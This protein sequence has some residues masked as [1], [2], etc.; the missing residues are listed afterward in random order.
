[1]P[2]GEPVPFYLDLKRFK[3]NKAAAEKF[4]SQV[5]GVLATINEGVKLYNDPRHASKQE[6]VLEMLALK[7]K[8]LKALQ[9]GFAFSNRFE[10]Y[11]AYVTTTLEQHVAAR[12]SPKTLANLVDEM[13]QF[14]AESFTQVL[15]KSKDNKAL[16]SSLRKFYPEG[17]SRKAAFEFFLDTHEISIDHVGNSKNFVVQKIGT[18]E[19][20]YLK[21]EM[22]GPYR[23]Q[24]EAHLRAQP[25]LQGVFT[26]NFAQKSV[27]Y[28]HPLKNNE[29]YEGTLTVTEYCV[30]DNVQAHGNAFKADDAARLHSAVNIYK[31]M[32][33]VLAQVKASG[34]AFP[35]LKNKNWLVDSTGKLRISD[36]KTFVPTNERGEIT[37]DTRCWHTD[38]VSPPELLQKPRPDNISVDKMHAYMLGK[39]LY[40]YLTEDHIGLLLDGARIKTDAS[41][42]DFS[43]PIF[44]TPVGQQYQAL[45]EETVKDDPAVRLTVAEF[46]A[47]IDA[48]QAS[49][50]LREKHAQFETL[51]EKIKTL[52][53][54]TQDIG[55]EEYIAE[56]QNTVQMFQGT[57]HALEMASGQLET[58]FERV[59]AETERLKTEIKA[60][61]ADGLTDLADAIL[62]AIH[63]VPLDKRAQIF[64]HKRGRTDAMDEVEALF[65]QA[66]AKRQERAVASTKDYKGAVSEVKKGS[67]TPE[68]PA[69][70]DT[71]HLK[72]Q[73]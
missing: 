47:R 8:E 40:R 28:A 1:M 26:Q 36:A 70:D 18:E 59:A 22:K 37:P 4:Q 12:Q 41:K 3:F 71:E 14:D 34:C 33:G 9:P 23:G 44:Q 53:I 43:M 55:I 62:V 2:L 11:K 58:T 16:R 52:A 30:G 68:A 48:V 7:L 25:G 6:K 21:V 5:N 66:E 56:A 35:D 20:Q 39:N 29:V 32:A 63:Q 17:D 10:E 15:M 60:L 13:S 49:Y 64:E 31:Q 27:S 61:R 50:T 67:D 19:R 69:A 45:I 57:A 42:L 24:P 46:E 51:C 38:T 73:Q 54:G 65:Q 72:P